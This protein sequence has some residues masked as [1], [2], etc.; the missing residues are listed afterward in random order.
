MEMDRKTLSR[1]FEI[2]KDTN[3]KALMQTI[4]G[5]C[6]GIITVIINRSSLIQSDL[7]AP[8]AKT[9]NRWKIVVV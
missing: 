9:A 4:L 5:T 1:L 6:I 7:S 3:K 2:V 8:Y